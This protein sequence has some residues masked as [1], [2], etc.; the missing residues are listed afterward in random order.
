MYIYQCF[1]SLDS[2]KLT[3]IKPND[4]WDI[5]LDAS[6][7]GWKININSANLYGVYP[8]GLSNFSSV[9]SVT[10]PEKYIFDAS[11]GFPDSTAFNKWLNRSVNPFQPTGEIFL[12][13][14]YTG[15]RYNPEWMVKFISYTDTSYTL[16]F[17]P[18]G[19]SP[20]E[21][22]IKKDPVYNKMYYS[23]SGGGKLVNIEPAKNA[24]DIY[25]TQYGT[26]LFTNEGI[27]TPYFVRGVLI[28]PN[29]VAVSIDSL[30]SFE[31]VDFQHASQL[32][33]N[34][35]TD[36]IGYQW[37]EVKVDFNSGTAVYIT[38]S[39][40]N[41]IIRDVK[42]FLYKLRF[43]DFYNSSGKEGFPSF[44]MQKL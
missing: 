31:E 21:K 7:S 32:E 4:S 10:E 33:F 40:I 15:I 24:W 23:F 27:P 11:S 16:Q 26:I 14:K 42:G 37:K 20:V 17:A 34:N 41:Y 29:G 36:I 2:S 12:I 30:S 44:E 9:S 38:R 35:K 6:A 39:D 8:T 43:I 18:L 5:A 13:G 1:F 3:S 19:G 28:N 25:F 22:I